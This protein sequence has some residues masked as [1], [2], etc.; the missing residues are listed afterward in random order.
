[1]LIVGVSG[2]PRMDQNSEKILEYALNKFREEGHETEK[3]LL[4][5]KTMNPCI[6]CDGCSEADLCQ[7][8]DEANEVNKILKRA[9]AIFVVTPVYFGSMTAQMKILCDKTLPLR[10]NGFLLKGKL[11]AAIAVGKSRNGGQELAVKDIHSWML[12]HGMLIAGDNSHFGGT[13]V[14]E[15]EDDKIGKETVD[16]VVESIS[17]YFKVST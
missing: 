5:N 2:S 1:M 15:F 7:Y 16:G 14:S 13:V 12:I 9:A 10:R 3:I 17:S 6:A 4:R 8:D 11:G